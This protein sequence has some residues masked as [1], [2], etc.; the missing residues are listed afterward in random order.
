MLVKP[1]SAALGSITLQGS[2]NDFITAGQGADVITGGS[3]TDVFTFASGDTGIAQF[4][5][6]DT[7][8]DF[9][10]NVDTIRLTSS[11]T[12]GDV[13]IKNWETA[14]TSSNLASE[15]N[16]A[17]D[18]TDVDI[19]VLVSNF[20]G[21]TVVVDMDQ[22]GSFGSGDLMIQLEP[23]LSPMISSVQIWRGQLIVAGGFLSG[24]S[25][26]KIDL[27]ERF[28]RNTFVTVKGYYNDSPKLCCTMRR[29][30]AFW[31]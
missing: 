26:K 20:I 24:V 4:S 22:S 9:T 29:H 7:I 30:G 2:G 13:T 17:F 23:V 5:D 18:G 21:A 8:T 1:L 25:D 16:Q 19:L 28:S 27:G 6:A 12:K 10:K 14:I 31:T 3:G 15:A 11:G